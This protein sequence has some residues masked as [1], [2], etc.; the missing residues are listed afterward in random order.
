MIFCQ[1]EE[2]NLLVVSSARVL[3]GVPGVGG[4]NVEHDVAEV[5]DRLGAGG[6][7]QGFAVEL[8]FNEEIGIVDGNKTDL[9]VYRFAVFQVQKILQKETFK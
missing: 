4:G 9:Q 6:V 2:V 5:A 3:A 1:L 8:P 7:G